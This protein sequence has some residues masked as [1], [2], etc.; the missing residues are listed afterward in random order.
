MT[1]NSLIQLFL[2]IINAGLVADGFTNVTVKR[3][4]QPTQQGANSNPTVYFFPIGNKRY[5]FLG[6]S[7]NW[8]SGTSQMVHKEYQYM[9]STFQIQTLVKQYPTDPSLFTAYDL[10][11]EVS[12]ILQSDATIVTLNNAGVGI[13]R[14]SELRQPH[15][16]DDHDNF[17]A[18]PSFDFTLTYQNNRTLNTPIVQLPIA[19]D[20]QG[21]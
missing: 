12:S 14:I 19:L 16:V 3:A 8:D 18:I 5:G 20:I 21:V 9:E 13:L 10:L 1:E 7:Y 2:P 4:N 17:A 11:Y 6:R 15:F